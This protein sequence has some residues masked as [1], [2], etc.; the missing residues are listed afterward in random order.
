MKCL[1]ALSDNVDGN[2]HNKRWPVYVIGSPS[3]IALICVDV[4]WTGLFVR[5]SNNIEM[6]AGMRG[7][8]ASLWH[9]CR[10]IHR[11]AC[12]GGDIDD[13]SMACCWPLSKP[14]ASDLWQSPRLCRSAH[15]AQC[16]FNEPERDA[17]HRTPLRDRRRPTEKCK[18]RSYKMK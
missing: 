13:S 7:L 9:L 12:I 11:P 16:E 4:S 15:R 10:F 2:S 17:A 3:S 5:D 1:V 14:V 8:L 6:Y 18:R